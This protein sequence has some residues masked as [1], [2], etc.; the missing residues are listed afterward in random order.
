MAARLP[1]VTTAAD[2]W[3]H[4]D[5]AAAVGPE[6]NSALP[7]GTVTLLLADIEGSTEL[8]ER[9]PDDMPAV[10]AELDRL[11]TESVAAHDGARPLEQG[12]GDSF[13]AAFARTS[14]AVACALAVQQL[15]TA[16][17]SLR[18]RMGLHAGEMQ[19]RDGRT[20][21]GRDVNRAA[22]L[23]DAARGGQVVLSQA[24]AEL[25]RDHL[26]ERASLLELGTIQLRGLNTSEHVFQLCHPDLAST[27]APLRAG[28]GP[29]SNLPVRLTSFV[30]RVDDMDAVDRLL[31]GAR[32]VTLTGSGGC[33]KTR[34]A[35]EVA[36][37]RV[38]SHP[39]G[40]WFVDL[41]L[42][43][44]P[45]SALAGVAES[46]GVA[47]ATV[48]VDAIVPYVRDTAAL[49]VLD[50]CEHLTDDAA[51]WAEALLRRCP[52]LTVLATSREPLGV[53]GETT[54]RVPSLSV[55]SQASLEVE[56]DKL[57]AFDAIALFV[58]RAGRARP[59]FALDEPNAATVVEICRR[60]E[61]LPLAIELAAARLR[62]L[63]PAQ[64]LDGLH[65]RFRLLTGGARAVPRQQTLQASV[66]WSYSLL[67]DVERTVLDR[68]SVF[69][70]GFT[71]DAADAV[72]AGGDVEVS[73]VLDIVLQ[74]VDK[75]LV[76]AVDHRFSLNETV[77]QYAAA[78]LAD[79]GEAADVRERHFAYVLDAVAHRPTMGD[80]EEEKRT[81]VMADYENIRRA[82]QWAA[83][84]DDPSGLAR[85]A[86]RLR[87]FWALGRKVGDGARWFA[88]VAERER[89]ESRRAKALVRL[90]QFLWLTG[91]HARAGAAYDEG[92]E[93]LRRSGD[94]RSV[95][96]ALQASPRTL[97]GAEHEELVAI[98]TEIGDDVL[99]ASALSSRGFALLAT[100]PE[101]AGALLEEA[102]VLAEQQGADP[103]CRL[104]R[105][106]LAFRRFAMGEVRDA[107][108][109]AEEAV[110]DLRAAG[111]GMTLGL[112]LPWVAVLRAMA[113]DPVGAERALAEVRSLR[114]EVGGAGAMIL[115]AEMFAVA[116]AHGSGHDDLRSLEELEAPS[117]A[118]EFRAT[119]LLARAMIAAY[120]GLDAKA[121]RHVEEASRQLGSIDT[122]GSAL[123]PPELPLAMA[124]RSRGELARA[125]EL[126]HAAM[127]RY[128]TRP[129][130]AYLRVSAVMVLAS[131]WAGK[132]RAEEAARL[133][134]GVWA[135]AERVGMSWNF[136]IAVGGE[137][138]HIDAC[139][140]ALGRE[141]FDELWA[142][143][144]AMSWDEVI[145]YAQRGRGRGRRRRP[146]HG[147]DS[148]TATERQVAGTVAGGATNREVAERLF[149]SVATVKT[150]LTSV[151]GKLGVTSRSQ[152]ASQ[153]PDR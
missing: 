121:E 109:A 7:V 47:L 85:L 77:R 129:T 60:L 43:N 95:A 5:V 67:L 99:R 81:A 55:P 37:G 39:G 58:E 41:S 76:M 53:D 151:Y 98:A 28:H 14:D 17:G 115:P 131:L 36:A 11:V 44:E 124:A 19:L 93:V 82:L 33:G 101:P 152:L 113:G 74:L 117:L 9:R 135:H 72:C 27:T 18:V 52:R 26:P 84:R 16:L 100:D 86:S 149:M 38:N 114:D 78:R 111:D 137:S 97:T 4:G 54:F 46:V 125:E 87:Y 31:D 51:S 96:E 142:Q 35:V 23:R 94:S 68:M 134:G 6:S 133:F 144:A 116:F 141:R 1:P 21:M 8:W 108:R 92:I 65:D 102:L 106:S 126:A 130:P 49:L 30:G 147:W 57:A 3:D 59:D 69:A 120:A 148:L 128:G 56:A 29:R 50:N 138:G 140:D 73:H 62:A 143:G 71:L 70:G 118:P 32:L 42:Y 110:G 83:E 48:T 119:W 105:T 63:T 123:I 122:S 145:A 112:N 88:V 24:A 90:G 61:G 79:S 2:P 15:T 132:D 89:D 103:L 22:R 40:V 136:A 25:V 127:N 64:I 146:V 139:R 45:E 150:H 34:L 80:T 12:E 10:L 104:A 20:Y 75:S 153:W 66:D 107:V 91:E 13:V